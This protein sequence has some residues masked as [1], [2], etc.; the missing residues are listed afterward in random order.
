[1]D[2]L[3]SYCCSAPAHPHLRPAA[4]GPLLG[5]NL[6]VLSALAGTPYSSD[7]FRRDLFLE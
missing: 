3:F 4:L 5:G 6:T 7:L 2:R 1:V